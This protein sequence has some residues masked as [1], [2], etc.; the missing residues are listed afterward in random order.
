MPGGKGELKWAQLVANHFCAIN[1]RY[2]SYRKMLAL[3]KS[4]FETVSGSVVTYL[5]F[6]TLR[7]LIGYGHVFSCA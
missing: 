3:S 5:E 2:T 4:I 6:K 1:R 7:A